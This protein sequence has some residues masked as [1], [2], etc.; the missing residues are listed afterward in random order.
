MSDLRTIIAI[1]QGTTSSRAIL[2]DETGTILAQQSAEFPQHFPADGWVEHDPE[3]IWQTTIDVTTTMVAEEFQSRQHADRDWHHQPARD[4]RHLGPHYRQAHPQ[5][6]CLAG[7][8]HRRYL[9]GDEECRQGGHGHGKTGL[10]L[11]PYFTASKFAWI[12]DRVEGARDRAAAGELC[13]GTIDNFLIWHLTGGRMHVTD[14][15]NAGRT[16]LYNIHENEWD[17]DLLALFDVPRTGLPQ[18]MD[19]ASNSVSVMRDFRCRAADPRRR[20]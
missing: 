6:D 5:R 2:F 16:S 14:A 18:V 7:P 17:D 19:C 1:D 4:R 9:R 15:T 20:R 8:A 12:L 11:D 13:F 10:L 3:D